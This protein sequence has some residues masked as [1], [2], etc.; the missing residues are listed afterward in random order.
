MSDF[1][2]EEALGKIYDSRL[3]RRMFAYLKPYR[4]TVAGSVTLLLLVSGLQ[5]A[6]PFILK[7]AIDDYVALGDYQ[8]LNW[9]AA[10]LLAVLVARFL[11][12]YLQNYL[13]DWT[14]Q[15]VMYDLRM[16]IFEH[17]QKLHLSYFDRH[18][19]GRIMTRV[20]TDVD[21]LNELFTQ[22][23]VSIFGDIFALSGIV[24][25]MLWINWKLALVSFAVIPVLALITAV[26]RVKVRG[27][28]RRVRAY[29]AKINSYLQEN[30]TGMV[31]A[32]VFGQRE[33]QFEQFRQRNQEH[34]D[35]FLDTIRYYAWFYPAVNFI[36]ALAV[37]LILWYGG[38]K[39]LE[40]T[41]TLGAV[42]AFI[43][44][45]ERF[46][47]PI[48]DLSEKFGLLQGAMAS[49]ERIFK[50]LDTPAEIVTP[51]SPQRPEVK[52]EI[53]FQDVSFAYK[54][55]APVLKEVSFRV[56]PG[57]KVAIVGATGAGKST[58]INLLGRFYD[59][60][61]GQIRIDGTEV[62]D[63]DLD[64]L[65][66]SMAIV[67][68]DVFLFTGTIEDNIRLWGAPPPPSALR[69]AAKRVHAD[70]FVERLPKQ[71]Q[72]AVAERGSSLSVGQRQLLAFARALARDPRILILDEATSSVDTETEVLIQDALTQLMQGRTS[73]IIAHRLS[74]IQN[75]DRILVLHKG[76]IV[77][78]G[79]HQQLL[80][81]RGLYYKLYQ[82]QY[83][84]Q[85]V[86]GARGAPQTGEV[87]VP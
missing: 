7:I 80:R 81:Q 44:Y 21:S 17:I 87:G 45:A 8:G 46:Y 79:A 85:L 73:L 51:A 20:T 58:I 42:V 65:R 5:V 19:V 75:C 12:F 27:V 76:R 34:R 11:I 49:S 25:A 72:T 71:Y 84:E 86:L 61:S 26:F 39:V 10:L 13:M 63:W 24:I 41:V 4:W 52:G 33:R 43:Q 69:E 2:E 56:R 74:T 36:G 53:E 35:A 29:V 47:R 3:T 57:E 62:R 6:G 37:A 30:I 18:P 70:R 32:Q 50:L 77:E 59:I 15:K 40:G 9:I 1:H 55:E 78:E 60:G 67:L 23:A 82:L 38:L 14:G 31:I 64:A 83:K 48:S 54:P 22:G 66:Q 68:Q 28:F 16:Q